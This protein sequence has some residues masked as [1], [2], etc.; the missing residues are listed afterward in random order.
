MGKKSSYTAIVGDS[1]LE[2]G[3]DAGA[4]VREVAAISGGK[5][6]GRKN[7]AQANLGDE[8]KIDEAFAGIIAIV[9]AI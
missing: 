7:I 3:Y 9:E 4:I 6:G 1:V 2:K 5:G 8:S